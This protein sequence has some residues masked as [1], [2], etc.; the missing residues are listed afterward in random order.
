MTT[1][2]KK[3]P[4][5]TAILFFSVAALAST[6]KGGGLV[7]AVSRGLVAGA[8]S[9]VFAALSAY[10]MFSEKLPEAKAPPELEGLEDKYRP[11]SGRG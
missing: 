10:I 7:T 1:M 5:I 6:I 4:Y 8:V 9:W 11:K 3:I 2:A